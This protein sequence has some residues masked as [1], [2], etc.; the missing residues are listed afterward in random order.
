MRP[1][2]SLITY[3]HRQVPTVPAACKA[4]RELDRQLAG[5]STYAAIRKIERV[6]EALKLL[7]GEVDTV[8]HAAEL[9]ILD[10][11]ARIGE[12]IAKLPKGSGRPAKNFPSGGKIK[13]NGRAATGVAHSSRSRWLKLNAIGKPRRHAIARQLQQSGKDATVSAVLRELKEG[14]IKRARAAFSARARRGGTVTDLIALAATGYRAAVIYADPAWQFKVY[15]GKGKQRSAERHYDTQM[16]DAIKSLPVAPLAAKDCTLF[17]W[18]VWPELQGALDVIK[19]WGFEYKTAAFVWVKQNRKGEGLFTG[20]GY[21]T[22]ANTE[23]C[24]LATRGSPTR[25]AKNVHQ[26]IFTPVLRHSEKPEETRLRIESLLIGPYLELYGRRAIDRPGWTV[27][28]QEVA[29]CGK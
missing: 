6:A 15:S 16:L 5:P 23:A 7:F 19:A 9:V 12:E 10:A 17:L 27:W 29:P 1:Q 25:D 3:I 28:G 11:K 24:L 4:L 18:C 20:M 8:K 21:H 22:R 2:T 26:V 14:E 13:E